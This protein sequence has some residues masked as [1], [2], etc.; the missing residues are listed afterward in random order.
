MEED[1]KERILC[2][3]RKGADEGT[4]A[5]FVL[6][7][8]IFKMMSLGVSGASEQIIDTFYPVPPQI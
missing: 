2:K 1:Q 5:V 3:E 8:I 7:Q 6:L 4:Y